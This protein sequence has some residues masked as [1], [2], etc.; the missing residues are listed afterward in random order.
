MNI[1]ISAN[2]VWCDDDD[3]SLLR[4][5]IIGHVAATY[6]QLTWW[7]YFGIGRHANAA[8]TDDLLW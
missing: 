6:S 2:T 8:F 1:I 5:I 7:Y 4:N 3:F